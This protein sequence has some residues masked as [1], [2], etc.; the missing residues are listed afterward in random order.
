MLAVELSLVLIYAYH[1]NSNS[2]ETLKELFSFQ[3]PFNFGLYSRS[4]LIILYFQYIL[5]QR[6]YLSRLTISLRSKA[7]IIYQD[8]EVPFCME[9]TIMVEFG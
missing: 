6:L 7:L 9:N 2:F 4:L 1:Q 8:V 3:Y 5:T